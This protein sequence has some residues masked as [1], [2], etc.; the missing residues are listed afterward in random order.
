MNDDFKSVLGFLSTLFGSLG[1]FI[2]FVMSLIEPQKW[3]VLG[4]LGCVLVALT[5]WGLLGALEDLHNIRKK[6]WPEGTFKRF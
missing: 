4:I 5:G 2:I 6:N 3:S 1:A